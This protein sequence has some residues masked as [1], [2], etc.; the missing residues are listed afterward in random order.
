MVLALLAGAATAVA[1]PMKRGGDKPGAPT[2]ARAI[3]PA[4]V[5]PAV[6]ANARFSADLLRLLAKGEGNVF[7]SPWSITTALDMARLGA[8][9]PAL[10]A[11]TSG[12]RLPGTPEAEAALLALRGAIAAPAGDLPKDAFTLVEAN[13]LWTSRGGQPVLSSYV[14]GLQTRFGA[15]QESA[16]FADKQAAATAVN[17]W[18]K[19]QTRGLIPVLL[20]PGNIPDDGLILTNAVYF[21]GRWQTEFQEWSTRPRPFKLADGT[22]PDVPTMMLESHLMHGSIPDAQVVALNYLG[23]A[24]ALFILP[25][26]GKMDSVIQ[27]LDLAA[28]RAS[29]SGKLVQL[30]APKVDIKTRMSV[31]AQMKSMGMAPAFEDTARFPKMTPGGEM[32][33]ADVIH[34]AA[35]K[36]DEKKT[37]AAGATGVIVAPTSAPALRDPPKPLIVRLDRP[38]LVVITHE[39]TGAVLF[40]GRVNDPRR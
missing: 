16:D 12:L 15:D 38:Y 23:P 27:R 11:L 29:L 8:E 30:Y 10:A 21:L 19:Q 25:D 17:N 9:G 24:R 5:A 18:V 40:A 14:A 4:E 3:N 6:Q 34:A 7:F 26:E 13:R 36:M 33:I 1:A 35:L 22:S 20:D 2:P 37:E 31:A 32:K 28:L 39:P